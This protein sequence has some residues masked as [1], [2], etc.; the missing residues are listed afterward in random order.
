MNIRHFIISFAA[1]FSLT[2]M[3][4]MPQ[5]RNPMLW[6]DVPDPDVIRVDS[7]FY[8]VSTTM[9]LM[10]GGPV[11]QSKDLANWTLAS[12]MFP[13]LDNSPYCS[14]DG[15][16]IYGCGQWA[17]SLRYHDGT[18]YALFCTN[19]PVNADS[20]VFATKDPS[21]GWELHSRIPHFHDPSLFFDDD[22]RAYVFHGS[23]TL[24][25]LQPDLKGIKEGGINQQIIVRDEEE[26][27]L[28]EGSRVI[29][30]DG[31][32][33]ALMISWPQGKPRRQLCYRAD[34]ITGPYEKRVILEDNFAGFPYVGQGTIVDAPD[35]RW[36][37]VIFQDRGAVGRVLTLEPCR[38]ED[39][40]PMLGDAN[41]KI[42]ET[43]PIPV[44]NAAWRTEAAKEPLVTSDDFSGKTLRGQWQWNHNPVDNAWSL[45]DRKGWLRLKTSK[46]TDN[47][48]AAP[49]TLS[50]RTE[51]PTC[52]GTV[53]IDI[54]KMRDGDR[55]GFAAFNGDAAVLTVERNGKQWVLTASGQSVR[56]DG[57]KR[58][59]TKV[60]VDEWER[61]AL[62]KGKVW[63]RVMT[64]F[65]LNRDKATLA[66]STDGKRWTPIGRE[67]Q[68]RY[69]YTRVFMGTR[70]ALFC[71]ATKANGGYVDV[72]YFNY[73]KI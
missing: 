26:T 32:Y 54:S 28:L 24:T 10:P 50:Q 47:L 5:M 61:V 6:A 9:H 12:Y 49:N 57:P 37:G 16:S 44:D 48:F 3:A 34:S 52:E 46:V 17:T 40:W 41:G 45:T 55:A 66:Y 19:D 62:T 65:R 58:I 30:K 8:L 51:G 25:E 18:F 1:A 2:A 4:Q 59:I 13:R 14:L 71:Y 68:L 7:T 69:D 38:W 53:C 39:G 21:K 11:Y 23:G 29:K 67:Y 73:K 72:D 31:K 27:A 15:G 64:D 63:L 36:Y 56:L 22:G 70:L 20:Y 35:G 43:M 60:D 42:P 33:Y